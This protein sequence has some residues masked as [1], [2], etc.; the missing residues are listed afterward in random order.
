MITP[1]AHQRLAAHTLAEQLAAMR[2]VE[3]RLLAYKLAKLRQRRENHDQDD[4]T[5]AFEADASNSHKRG[6][7]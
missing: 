3:E 1:Q 4:I 7:E 2:E 6:F 5:L